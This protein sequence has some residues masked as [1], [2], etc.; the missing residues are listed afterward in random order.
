M[1]QT[2]LTSILKSNQVQLDGVYRLELGESDSIT[3]A[4]APT[5]QAHSAPPHARLVDVNDQLTTIE[6]KCPCGNVSQIQCS[7]A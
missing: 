4:S 3:P 6:L 2:K 1:P 5:T 7:F